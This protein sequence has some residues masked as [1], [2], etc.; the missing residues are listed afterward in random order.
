M[1]KKSNGIT[2][3]ALVITIIVL[4]ILAG[5]TIATLSGDSG[6]LTNAAKAKKMALLSQYKEEHEMFL[7]E[8]LLKNDN[9]KKVSLVAGETNLIYNTQEE[10]ETGNIYDVIPSLK[11]NDFSTKLEII[12]GELLLNT[13]DPKEIKMAQSIGIQVNPYDIVDGELLSSNGNLL[14]MDETGTVTIPDNVTKIGEGAFANLSGLKT[15]IIPGSVKVIGV[16]AFR[17]NPTLE[18]VII[19]DGLERIENNA[20]T[21]CENLIDIIMPDSITLMGQEIFMSCYKLKNVKLSESLISLPRFTFHACI[22]LE[23]IKIPDRVERLEDRCLSSCPKLNN[24]IIN[25]NITYIS[26][27]AFS[28][29][30]ILENIYISNNPNFVYENGILMLKSKTEILFISSKKLNEN[31]VFKIPEGITT[32]NISISANKNI[33]TIIIPKSLQ[34]VG[35]SQSGIFPM[36]VNNIQVTEGNMNFIVKNNTLYSKDEKKLILCFEKGRTVNIL[37]TVE[38]I[39]MQGFG[40]APNLVEI[41]LPD[42]VKNIKQFAII[43]CIKLE[44][45]RIGKNVTYIDPLFQY[46]NTTLNLIIDPLNQNYIVED[47]VLYNKD[48]TELMTTLKPNPGKFLVKDTVKV[49]G[50]LAFY[51]KREITE[52]ILPE[53]LT[54]IKNSFGYCSF[55]KIEIPSTVN[56]ISIAAFA[57]N[58]NLSQIIINKPPN[59][60]SGAPWGAAKGNRIV[61]WKK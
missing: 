17:N 50:S 1:N 3:V 56:T 58:P 16:N 54:E 29:C 18:K 57:N 22:S 5:V 25:Q 4:L 38:D 24:I 49:I 19:K 32:F 51:N 28:D 2:L 20:F 13:K 8:Q 41:N 43:K 42:S 60:I 61:E 47:F 59:S 26:S 39:E 53:G 44:T 7:N 27:S 30:D 36:S 35:N 40:L 33:D 21:S 10:G 31:N 6:I 12:K 48:K 15:I 37:P 45:M 23:K 9:F 55:N 46:N 34:E 14:L 11:N 52:I